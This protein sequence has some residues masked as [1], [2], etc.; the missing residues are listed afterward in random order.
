MI[1]PTTTAA[2]FNAGQGRDARPV[3]PLLRLRRPAE[4]RATRVRAA[5]TEPGA[6]RVRGR[7]EDPGRARATA[8]LRLP[9]PDHRRHLRPARAGLGRLRRLPATRPRVRVDPPAPRPPSGPNG[10]RDHAGRP[11][12]DRRAPPRIRTARSSRTSAR[13]RCRTARRPSR[14]SSRR[15]P[16]SPWSRRCS[17]L[18][19]SRCGG[20]G[21]ASFR[22]PGFGTRGGPTRSSPRP[23]CSPCLVGAA[24][25]TYRGGSHLDPA[26]T[27][28][29][30]FG[31]LPERPRCLRHLL[32]ATE[33]AAEVVVRRGVDP[34]RLRPRV[35]GA[36]VAGLEHASAVPTPRSTSRSR[37]RCSPAPAS[38]PSG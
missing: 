31:E 29:R 2:P 8:A 3:H 23:R 27:R 9:Q 19:R 34:D 22:D 21:D 18:R 6:E 33:H 5:A 28:Y 38:P 25:V 1:V 24:M 11:A 7:A 13:S 20:A 12:R 17:G 35:V 26:A 36:G 32:G 10:G 14:C 30:F 4:G 37:A 16:A 15:S